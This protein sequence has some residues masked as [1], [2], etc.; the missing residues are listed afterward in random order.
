MKKI[1]H[2][3]KAEA[4]SPLETAMLYDGRV[5]F[6]IPE[7]QRQYDWEEENI[8]RLYH[9]TLNGFQRL[10]ASPNA[11]A[12]T[13]LGTLILVEEK[14]KEPG[15]RGESVAIVDG[16]QRLTTLT[17]FACALTE[18]LRRQFRQTEFP[19]GIKTRTKEW[20]CE[21]VK[22]RLFCLYACAVGLQQV[23]PRKTF[24]FPRI[25]RKEDSRGRSILDSEYRS[26]IG[27]FLNGFATYFDSEKEA[28]LP[29]A[30]GGGTDAAKLASNFRLV[31]ELVIGLNEPDWYE[32]TECEQFD[33]E[34]TRRGHC[35]RLFERL[36]DFVRADNERDQAI[37]SIVKHEEMHDLVRTL[38][39]SAYFCNCIV[40]TRVTTEDEST[41]FDIFDA[42]NTTGQPLTALE[43]LK[44]RVINFE[45]TKKGY[46]GSDSET[47]FETINQYVDQRFS[48]T[49]K[50]QLET[51]DLIVNFA[52][53]LEGRKLSKDLAAQ[54]N[55]LRRS[56]D[57]AARAS[58]ESARKYTQ[59]LA[60]LSQ[61]RRYYWERGGIEELGRFHRS[62]KVDEVQVLASLISGMKTSLALPILARYWTPDLKHEGEEHFI[63][64][65]RAVVAFLILRRA[66]TGGTAGIDSDFRAIMAPSQGRGASRKFSLCA[67]AELR[68]PALS[69][70][71]LKRALKSLL[72]YKLKLLTRDSWVRKV[73][74]NPLYEQSRELARFMI[75]AAANQATPSKDLP[76]TW[77][78]ADFKPSP[79]TNDFLNYKTWQ[80]RHYATVEHIA[81]SVMPKHGWNKGLYND[82]ILRH[83]LG[84]LILLPAKE[85]SV[86]GSSSWEK[87]KKFYEALTETSASEQKKKIEEATAAG[88]RMSQSTIEL[89]E[90]GVRL[91]LL[92]PLRDV[93]SWN[94]N[95]VL[96][97]GKNIAELC[98]DVV[99][100]W[101]N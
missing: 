28:F 11:N 3:F 81:P 58:E 65:L 8:Q 43:T 99:C 42:L 95:I 40:L 37:D 6:V 48:E 83:S 75:L 61:F 66:A 18:A 62:E 54:R 7:Y 64:A 96:R 22:E 13:F 68:K 85:N 52:L 74:A 72:E 31:R 59:S 2:L 90:S 27:R 39:F 101:L 71:N 84:N 30:L 94:S 80:G 9:D 35:R 78:R 51:K 76:G 4:A 21:E 79:N 45:E 88:I 1:D 55:F 17:L 19:S 97:R 47:A 5:G 87:K 23:T 86:I 98:W 56:F 82:N 53:Y 49:V 92:D 67:G 32:D 25:V 57:S 12:F 77:T 33:I 14:S 20:L 38:L 46:G 63:V 69:T 60:E 15:F 41:A 70:E 24:P 34:W 10:A 44:P 36:T 50:K 73:T 91:S 93:E 100:K 16:Q 89:L 26:P 29:P